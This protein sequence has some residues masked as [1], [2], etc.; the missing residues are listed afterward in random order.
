MP[1]FDNIKVP[2]VNFDAK[3]AKAA[4]VG[5][6][7]G[8]AVASEAA[9]G[10]AKYALDMMKLEIFRDF[11]QFLG[12][13]FS[14]IKLPEG[15]RVFFGN[16]SSVLS[17]SL[18]SLLRG[19]ASITSW[20]W[21]LIFFFIMLVCWTMLYCAMRQ[22]TNVSLRYQATREA[23]AKH[24]WKLKNE[25]SM[26]E[27]KK[28]KY[29]LLVLMTI[30]VPVT[31][32]SL[33]M[34]F[35]APK[36]A[37]EQIKCTPKS[38]SPVTYRY[39]EPAA[40]PASATSGG[41]TSGGSTS[42]GSTSSL[43]YVR[44]S[45]GPDHC[46]TDFEI[47]SA[48]S[49]KKA[50][51]ELRLIDQVVTLSS[52]LKTPGGC[53][54]NPD[55]T[56]N[57]L[58]FSRFGSAACGSSGYDC[59][60][61]KDSR[62]TRRERQLDTADYTCP[63][64][65]S[66][67]NQTATLVQKAT[68]PQGCY[69]GNHYAFVGL[70]VLVLLL[71]TAA[72]PIMI[73]KVVKSMKPKPA[74][75]ADDPEHP[76]AK[77]PSP[78]EGEYEKKKK[79]YDALHGKRVVFDDN[80]VLVE[81]TNKIFLAEVRKHGQNPYASLYTG[82]EMEWANYKAI[83]MGMKFLQL[84]PTV[85][86]TSELVG[87]RLN[88]G[89]I[90]KTENDIAEIG[91]SACAAVIM[92]AFLYLAC[93]ASPYVDP[94]ND[95]MDHVSR[96]VLFITPVVA[97]IS[98][99][100]GSGMT[101]VWTIVLNL[102]A[103]ASAGFSLMMMIYVMACCQ[104]KMKG[105]T[106]NLAFS[107]P[108]GFTLWPDHSTLP[109]WDLD[110]ERKRRVWKPFWDR[111]FRDD[112]DLCNKTAAPAKAGEAKEEDGEEKKPMGEGDKAKAEAKKKR[113]SCVRSVDG[114]SL[115][116]PATRLEEM[117][118][119]LRK[120]GFAAW[121]SGLMPV[122]P[123]VAKMRV[124]FQTLFEGPDIFCDDRWTTD[125]GTSAVKDG[126]LDSKNGFGRLEVEPFPFALKV[127]WDGSGKD[128]GEIPSWGH[129]WPRLNELWNMQ[130]RPEVQR[131]KGIRVAIRGMAASGQLF[132]LTQ[133]RTTTETKRVPD[134]KDADGNQKYRNETI[135]IRWTYQNG[136]VQVRGDYGNDPWEQGFNVSMYYTDGVGIASD[137]TTRHGS[138][139]FGADAMGIQH[140]NYNLTA[141]LRHLLGQDGHAGNA[142]NTANGIQIYNGRLSA[143]RKKLLLERFWDNY[144]LSWGFWYHVYNNDVQSQETLNAYFSGVT[145][146][147]KGSGA[148]VSELNPVI[149]NLPI[150]YAKE[151]EAVCAM[152]AHFN[153]NPA[154]AY[155]YVY[156]HDVWKQNSDV[157]AIKANAETFDSCNPGAICYTPMARAELETFL[158]GL[159]PA[160]P[161]GKKQSAQLDLLYAA[162]EEVTKKHA[163]VGGGSVDGGAATTSTEIAVEV[164]QDGD[165]NTGVE[166][167]STG[168][169]KVD[170]ANDD[171]DGSAVFVDFAKNPVNPKS[172]VVVASIVT[173]FEGA[174]FV[175]ADKS[176]I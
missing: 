146:G 95:K 56:G 18:S 82:F 155:W 166:M 112:P 165:D 127:F 102:S 101:I 51:T 158:G 151:I 66:G 144:Q 160:N 79:Q 26:F 175:N 121:E 116:Y 88:G 78:E 138:H 104:T 74:H 132:Q 136:K 55:A 126:S 83:V 58:V 108:N 134:G 96:A 111:I 24:N 131:M 174:V 76:Y 15:F 133:H 122:T 150:K 71:F 125:A 135:T 99:F 21:Y 137:G 90:N 36:Y 128:W 92:L 84:L 163:P 98:N 148:A 49:C 70:S 105:L 37:Y 167:R 173:E 97:V 19:Y 59:V 13:F 14:S 130:L 9:Q 6:S 30:Y 170:V 32:N 48:E 4:L 46:G 103:A 156:W 41:S 168:E 159:S 115:P 44:K 162:V 142:A 117:L 161:L 35:C 64:S 62:H 176:A 5:A 42:G 119:H 20:Y 22:H 153:Q 69:A 10:C 149:Q 113:K 107:D 40:L 47:K 45:F 140:A 124:D 8:L 52:T 12:I 73:T 139:T 28:I 100:T 147:P 72:F 63:P 1:A 91:G 93:K 17:A 145:Q 65:A 11:F 141:N 106:G 123:Q 143:M 154:V 94:I 157:A 81:Y 23:K 129:H 33:Q 171:S 50:A 3:A 16:V 43:H 120:R 77:A 53:S 38:G 110:T 54:F 25:K 68:F 29:L 109:D 57:E 75:E 39:V 152:I 85:V 118:Q 114:T 169:G 34:I 7:A 2:K 31:R 172:E 89:D 60:C 80:G 67:E 61:A 27:Y 164:P 86:L 87:K